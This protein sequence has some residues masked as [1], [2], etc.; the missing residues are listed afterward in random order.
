MKKTGVVVSVSI[1][2]PVKGQSK[3]Y[4]G[5]KL[6]WE[7]EK[8]LE[9]IA[10]PMASLKYNQKLR[11]Q[12][13]ALSPG[14]EITVE[15]EK[16][17]NDFWEIKSITKGFD[18]VDKPKNTGVVAVGGTYNKQGA[19]TTGRD[20]ETKDERELKQ[21]L[22]VAQSSLDKAI[23]LREPNDTEYDIV[24]RAAR[25]FANV[26][27]IATS[28]YAVEPNDRSPSNDFSDDIPF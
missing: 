11:S 6:N 9:Q 2:V 20:F 27:E 22:I 23:A 7:T 19:P 3:T 26:Y 8:G 24:Q 14:E 13:E 17:E 18:V 4:Q 10:K 5:W 15:Q 25:L 21:K 12:L 28:E 16:N 1:D